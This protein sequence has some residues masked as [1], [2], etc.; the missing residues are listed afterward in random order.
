MGD[1][2]CFAQRSGYK[3]REISHSIFFPSPQK[4]VLTLSGAIRQDHRALSPLGAS[5]QSSTWPSFRRVNRERKARSHNRSTTSKS[6]LIANGTLVVCTLIEMFANF[7]PDISEKDSE[8]KKQ[9]KTKRKTSGH[10]I[11]GGAAALIFL[12]VL[13]TLS[14]AFNSPSRSSGLS[15][16]SALPSG[17]VKPA[18]QIKTLTFA[19]RVAYQ[20]AIEEVYWR[21]RIWPKERPDPKPSLDTVMSQAQLE[22]KVEDYLRNSQ[23]LEDYWHQPITAEQL[24]GEMDR[25]AQHT[26]QP[27]VLRE[28]FE[29]LGND[30]F[31]IAECLARPVLAERSVTDFSAHD[32]ASLESWRAKSEN[33]VPIAP[34]APTVSYTLPTISDGPNG[35]IDDTWTGTTINNAPG[36]RDS[37]TA[38]WTGSEMIV[39]GG[40]QDLLFLN[41][42]GRYNPSTDTWVATST[43][44]APAARYQ[45]T[46]VWTGS[47]MIVWGGNIGDDLGLNTGG[48]YNPSTNTWVTTSTT[49]APAARY[50]HTAVWTG[51]EMIVWGGHDSSTYL[52]TGG[53]YHPGTD[54]WTATSTANAP[55]SRY[56]HTAVWS[57][58]EMIVWAGDHGNQLNTGGRYNPS[59]DTWTATSITNAPTARD[60]HTA[61][62]AGSEMIIWSGVSGG[63]VNTG[64]RYNP[65][66]DNWTA[67]STTNAPTGRFFST[68]V[69]TDSEMIVWG[70]YVA[71]GMYLNT[72]GRYTPATDGWTATSTTNAPTGREYHTA[73]WTGSEMIVWGGYSNNGGDVRTGGRYCAQSGATPTPTATATATPT[74]T[75]TPTGT[76]TATTTPTAT[77]TGTPTATPTPTGTATATPIATPR[78]TPTA[79][80]RPTPVPRPT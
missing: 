63:F 76:A 79:R 15:W 54:S 13:I 35:C 21:H 31:V 41:T 52:D 68:A 7:A 14:S 38:V 9:M 5:P 43:A 17:I 64:G 49:N 48:R 12:S 18:K 28:L 30:P 8:R 75:P 60:G 36:L 33:Q 46:A 34:V 71:V 16:Q 23:A 69:W 62:W 51:S 19:D 24:Q 2:R 72:G 67:T 25:M 27:E 78:T 61:I 65:S 55:L 74:A 80:P 47:E 22:K 53:R 45:H 29:A 10:I 56:Y 42:G 3:S 4:I 50:L 44:N 66:T 58:S 70:G 40:A 26:R 59:M 39:W 57:G 73:V 20:R 77:A 11:R 1:A 6:T 32:Q 37:H